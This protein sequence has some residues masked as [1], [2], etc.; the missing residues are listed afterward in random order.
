MIN[1]VLQ[2]LVTNA[3]KFTERGGSV[4]V[5]AFA[6]SDQL[7][8]IVSDSGVGMSEEQIMK[9]FKLNKTSSA[10]GTDDEVGTGLGLIICKEFI[11]LHHGKIW[12]ESTPGQGSDFCFSVALS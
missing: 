3:I 12:V 4:T 2:N 10:R 8:F 5:K 6:E 1:S 9:L 7:K 11:E